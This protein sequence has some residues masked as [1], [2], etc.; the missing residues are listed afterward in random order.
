MHCYHMTTEGELLESLK[1]DAVPSIIFHSISFNWVKTL[2]LVIGQWLIHKL[3]VHATKDKDKFIPSTTSKIISSFIHLTHVLPSRLNAR[4]ESIN[5]SFNWRQPLVVICII[6]TDDE[7]VLVV[8]Q[9]CCMSNSTNSKSTVENEV[10]H[11]FVD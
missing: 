4:I 5:A 3:I 8:D 9:Y 7:N 11:A 10:V 1:I 2:T 6:A